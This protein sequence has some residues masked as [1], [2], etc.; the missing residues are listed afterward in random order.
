MTDRM[1]YGWAEMARITGKS[2]RT[3]YKRKKELIDAG[4]IGYS[5]LGRPPKRI[6]MVHFFPDVL[7]AYISRKNMLGENF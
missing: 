6:R 4:V 2:K 5:I 3:L 1:E 7:K